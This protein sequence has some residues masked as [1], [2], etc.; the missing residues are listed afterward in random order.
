MRVLPVPLEINHPFYLNASLTVT[1]SGDIS[2]KRLGLFTYNHS[3]TFNDEPIRPF[4]PAPYR[5]VNADWWASLR[6][7]ETSE[8]SFL[9][10]LVSRLFDRAS[11]EVIEIK[12]QQVILIHGWGNG[13]P[14]HSHGLPLS[15]PSWAVS[16]CLRAITKD[17][18]YSPIFRIGDK[19]FPVFTSQNV[20]CVMFTLNTR[21]V[22]HEVIVNSDDPN[23]YLWYVVD[24]VTLRTPRVER[25]EL[26]C[27]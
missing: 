21:D 7:L 19:S 13:I 24:G 4:T 15:G 26:S 12:D 9:L 8:A 14:L 17:Q 1:P 23:V 5:S 22:Q 3:R 11:K 20:N 18:R 10:N 16:F 25:V 2:T 27:F 6:Y